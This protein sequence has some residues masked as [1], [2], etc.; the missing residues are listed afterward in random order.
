MRLS[1]QQPSG[2]VAKSFTTW[3]I[4]PKDLGVSSR[5]VN[6]WKSQSLLPYFGG[7]AHLRMN[8]FQAMWF[9]VVDELTS[10]GVSSEKVFDLGKFIWKD[11]PAFDLLIGWV[12]ST[13]NTRVDKAEIERMKLSAKDPI[14]RISIDQEINHFTLGLIKLFHVRT[15]Q[16]DFNFFPQSNRWCFTGVVLND[17]TFEP[18]AFEQEP[19]IVI[20]LAA[21]FYALIAKELLTTGEASPLLEENLSEMLDLITRKKPTYVDVVINGWSKEFVCVYETTKSVEEIIRYVSENDIPQGSSLVMTKR[22]ASH[23]KFQIITKS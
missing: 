21:K 18:K 22:N 1:N 9:A 20:P 8:I 19:R 16:F 4:T 2:I 10:L 13:P 5:K 11:S 17:E 12:E 7:G 15:R 23:Y 6:Y 14:W 3:S